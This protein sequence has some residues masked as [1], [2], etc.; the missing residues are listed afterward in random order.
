MAKK[1]KI[2]EQPSLDFPGIDWNHSDLGIS[3]LLPS[4]LRRVRHVEV[5]KD[6]RESG[7]PEDYSEKGVTGF[8][9]T[10]SGNIDSILERGILAGHPIS[11]YDAKELG[12]DARIHRGVFFHESP[13]TEYGDAVFKIN[14]PEGVKVYDEYDFAANGTRPRGGEGVNVTRSV[15]A[16]WL[17]LYGHKGPTGNFHKTSANPYSDECPECKVDHLWLEDMAKRKLGEQFQ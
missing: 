3:D 5:Y 2:E 4:A 13:H 1:K 17:S 14:V 12:V 8:H 6:A 10:D 16:S 15:P 11:G 7:T 9:A